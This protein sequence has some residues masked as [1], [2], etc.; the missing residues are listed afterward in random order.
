[1]AQLKQKSDAGFAPVSLFCVVGLLKKLFSFL[2]AGGG[3]SC[4]QAAFAAGC[5]AGMQNPLAGCF[6]QDFVGLVGNL[7]GLV[8]FADINVR[9]YCL[10]VGARR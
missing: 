2:G 7:F 8:E 6:V 10:D 5:I 3:Q 9:P 1:V 4:H